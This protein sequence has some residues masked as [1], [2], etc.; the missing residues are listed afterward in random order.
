MK[1]LLDAFAALPAVAK[2]VVIAI[3]IAVV[4]S[5]T[6]NVQTMAD[7][8]AKAAADAQYMS[9]FMTIVGAKKP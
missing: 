8:N 6:V 2:Y 5:V 7:R 3:S 1:A 4:V 9:D